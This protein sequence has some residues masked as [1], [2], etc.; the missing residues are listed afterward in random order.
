[1]SEQPKT[2]G[3]TSRGLLYGVIVGWIVGMLWWSS[4][5]MALGPS[6]RV[7]II[8]GERRETEEPV[9]KLVA[10]APLVAVPWAVVGALAGAVIGW[11][12]GW[13]EIV[14]CFLGMF[15]G[16]GFLLSTGPID[17]WLVLSMPL[18]AWTGAAGGLVLGRLIRACF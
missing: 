5:A 4:L 10:A 18:V 15:A 8:A 1:M 7:T 2:M 14:A 9:S 16:I 3:R 11:T 13:L 17:G 12:G 6:T